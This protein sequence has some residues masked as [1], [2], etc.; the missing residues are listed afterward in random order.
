M[1]VVRGSRTSHRLRR[2]WIAALVAM[3]VPLLA[4]RSARAQ[5]LGLN[6]IIQSIDV[7]DGGLVATT[8]QGQAVPLQLGAS[9]RQAGTGGCPILNLHLG[10]IDLNVLGLDVATS[11]ICLDVTG[12]RGPGNLLGNLLCSVGGL[13]DRGVP[14]S[15][16]LANLSA[17][18][19][20][21]LTAGLRDILNGAL[22]QLNSATV[23]SVQAVNGCSVLN[24][25][26]G[27]LDLNLLGLRVE[28]DNC[29]NGPVTVAV[30]AVPGAGNL[31]GNLLCN[32]LG[33]VSPGTTLQQLLQ[34]L[35]AA[36][37]NVLNGL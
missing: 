36:L 27:P 35:A 1:E 19:L 15:Q 10:P 32:L 25:V 5:P 9:P 11:P 28:L 17:A 12:V 37:L 26:L 2:V 22:N 23:Q 18:D 3:A 16:V 8:V 34:Q 20:A 29:S 21:R 7:V 33:S 30:T 13:L 14:L 4:A 31:L 6:N 24:L